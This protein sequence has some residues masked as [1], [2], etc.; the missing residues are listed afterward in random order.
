MISFLDCRKLPLLGQH[1]GRITT[2]AWSKDNL[3]AVGAEDNRISVMASSGTVL[4]RCDTNETPRNLKFSE[5]KREKRGAYEE[6]TVSTIIG[7]KHLGLWTVGDQTNTA[8]PAAG[9]QLFT[10]NFQDKY[11]DIIDY[12][13]YKN[14]KKFSNFIDFCL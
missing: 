1:S 7:K 5:M 4:Q 2:M 11:G 8:T 10:L 3:L 6:S 12:Q 13:W 14:T 9:S